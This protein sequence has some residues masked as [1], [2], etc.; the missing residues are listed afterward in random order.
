MSYGCCST[1]GRPV[2]AAAEDED[3]PPA[4]W[5]PF[6]EN[7]SLPSTRRERPDW[8]LT[9]LVLSSASA[10]SD[11]VGWNSFF[12]VGLTLRNTKPI[13]SH[14]DALASGKRTKNGK[15]NLS[16]NFAW[17]DRGSDHF[18]AV[19]GKLNRKIRINGDCINWSKS[20]RFFSFRFQLKIVKKL[21]LLFRITS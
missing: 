13:V 4:E 8:T 12:R 2:A 1:D 20:K 10:A 6:A 5:R 21:L 18:Q 3:W 9:S 17:V 14:L 7:C 15:L 19:F 11:G 16:T